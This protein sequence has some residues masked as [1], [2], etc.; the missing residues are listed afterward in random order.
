MSCN[1]VDKRKYMCLDKLHPVKLVKC[2]NREGKRKFRDYFAHI[3]SV[4]KKQCQYT[5]ERSCCD[6]EE[7]HSI[8]TAKRKL[9][10]MSGKFCFSTKQCTTCF[11]FTTMDATNIKLEPVQ[12]PNKKWKF[13]CTV[14]DSL[15]KVV[16]I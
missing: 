5:Y 6:Y 2:R 4:Q 8:R 15:N 14:H 1:Y 11:Q 12:L 16:A 3:T 10:E 13:D 9:C 7:N